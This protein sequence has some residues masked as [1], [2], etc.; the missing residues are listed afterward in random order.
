MTFSSLKKIKR[1]AKE[2]KR[3]KY[4]LKNDKRFSKKKINA[5]N[6]EFF[7][8]L[9]VRKIESLIVSNPR[10]ALQYID[11][12]LIEYPNDYYTRVLYISSLIVLKQFKMAHSLLIQLEEKLYSDEFFLNSIER[13][14]KIRNSI[15]FVKIKYYLYTNQ[16]KNAYKIIMFNPDLLY[17]YD[18][19]IVLF[20]IKTKLN[21][22]DKMDYF[23]DTYI[24]NQ[25][26]NYSESAMREHI[27]RHLSPINMNRIY[28]NDNVFACDFPID[29]VLSEIKQYL[30]EENAMY[31]GLTDDTYY[32][33]YDGCGRENNTVTD[34]FT[35]VCI[36]GTKD[37]IT[38]LPTSSFVYESV[39]DLNYMCNDKCKVRKL[40]K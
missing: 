28:R 26:L 13:F 11:N 36:H 29:I 1:V 33:R 2:M 6:G 5:K 39:I 22:M 7:D 34:Y 15:L 40:N 20:Y 31:F 8:L 18:L 24:F 4:A 16:L 19:D 37:I 25:I 38:I 10:L 12:Y 14:D 27:E 17:F 30:I 23:K 21:C 32:F 35:V 9:R 3:Q